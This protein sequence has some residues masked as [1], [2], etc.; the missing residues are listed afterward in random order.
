MQAQHPDYAE[1]LR[2]K[3]AEHPQRALAI[4]LLSGFAVGGGLSSRAS[5]QLILLVLQGLL[6][7]RLIP[8]LVKSDENGRRPRNQR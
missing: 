4:A 3:I 5:F 8:A 6:G 2:E 1:D 7:D